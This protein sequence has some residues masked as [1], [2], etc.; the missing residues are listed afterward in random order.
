SIYKEGEDCAVAWS[1]ITTGE[2][3]LAEYL[4][5]DGVAQ[6]VEQLLKLSVAEIICNDEMLF[7]TKSVKEVKHRLLPPFSSYYAWAYNEQH[8]QK[9]LLEQFDGQAIS[10]VGLLGHRH[11]VSAAG[12]L[13]EYL[14][15][16]QKHALKNII[17]VKLVQ[18][19]K[20]MRLDSIAV[21]NLELIKS[22]SDN[23]KY[24]SL[25]W[26]LD[27]TD[28]GMG[29]RMMEQM[30]ASPLKDIEDIEYRLNGVQELYDGTVVR[31]GLK[32]TL[33]EIRD[34]ER[35][36]GRISNN[37]L[38]P[39]D[40]IIL[41]N[42]L[43]AIPSVKFRLSGFTS[44]IIRDVD[45]SLLELKD[46]VD[47]LFN[48]I[49][50]EA[51]TVTKDGGYIKKG[52]CAELDE[53]RELCTNSKELK[54]KMEERERQATQ[55]PKLKI[56][57]NRVFGYYIEI[58]NS[59]KDKV[60]AHYIRRQ[61]V[62]N[63]ERYVTEE[64]KDLE[65]KILN[66]EEH[67]L[68]LEAQL[69]NQVK[70]VLT[71]N[72]GNLK[73]I[74]QGL[75]LLDCLVSCATVAKDNKYCRPKLIEAGGELKIVEGRHP[76]VEAISREKFIP[77]DTLLNQGEHRTMIIT[78]P[79]MAGKSTYMRQ[80]A[81]IAIMAHVGCFVP[82][83]SAT[84]P[85]IDRIFTR[86]GASDNLIFDQSTF[87]VEM[88]E[89]AAILKYATKDSL[90]IL[91]EVGRGTSMYD[92]LSIA[93]SVVEFLTQK[94]GAKTLFATHYHELTELEGKLEG[95]NN[96]K[97]TVKELAGTIVFLRKIQRGGANKS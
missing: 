24:G 38:N 77:N 63:A 28:T 32:E 5:E 40:C 21:R 87:M 97:V 20:L 6:A 72:I 88:N 14:R 60:P 25:F 11:A 62:S 22:N 45:A 56:G 7:A 75:A 73:Q 54:D 47:L 76:V 4:G 34:I 36:A 46:V 80:T 13:I 81:L 69:F 43:Q 49:D 41:H 3:V 94:I 35:I 74:S 85:L 39:R 51:S 1:D 64:L 84:V 90:L 29:S 9:T 27:R 70:D 92:G 57:Y 26:L 8:A 42:S 48:A 31:V 17:S 67:S 2:F 16:T 52:F 33:R 59:Y 44:K 55:I 65:H 15:E 12:A 91:D 78:G 66:A 93:W 82:A 50:P 10:S 19:D 37:K 95:V 89:V 96:Y 58:L 79:N 86:V 68:Q 23:K 71:Q 83:K 61:T 53:M 18:N 30:I